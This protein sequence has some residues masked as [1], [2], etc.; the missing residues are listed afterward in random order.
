MTNA[1]NTLHCTDYGITLFNHNQNMVHAYAHSL[2]TKA[3]LPYLG[4]G[5]E[6][7]STSKGLT[8]LSLKIDLL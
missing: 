8:T 6:L 1:V 5:D 2:H 7:V 3:L 4:G